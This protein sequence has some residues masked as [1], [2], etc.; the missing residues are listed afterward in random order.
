MI[1]EIGIDPYRLILTKHGGWVRNSVAS[2]GILNF[3]ESISTSKATRHVRFTSKMAPG[4]GFEPLWA[5]GP[6]A[7]E[8]SAIPLCHPGTGL[9]LQHEET[10]SL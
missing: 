6:L 9:N 1:R 8:A 7:L 10:R 4:K 5:R 3:L 2:Y